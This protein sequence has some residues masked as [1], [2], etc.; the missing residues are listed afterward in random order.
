MSD[1]GEQRRL[2]YIGFNANA[3]LRSPDCWKS[4]VIRK[5]LAGKSFMKLC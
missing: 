1:V 5:V 4:S 3:V 2:C